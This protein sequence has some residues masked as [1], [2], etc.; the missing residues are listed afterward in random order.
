MTEAIFGDCTVTLADGIV[1]KYRVVIGDTPVKMQYW[2]FGFIPD[3]FHWVVN[4]CVGVSDDLQFRIDLPPEDCWIKVGPLGIYMDVAEI[5]C[6]F[7]FTLPDGR[8]GSGIMK[9][10]ATKSW[11]QGKGRW[12]VDA[13]EFGPLEVD[14]S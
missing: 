14:V 10:T 9:G 7:T 13:V 5:P 2:F 6:P 4:A 8:K 12:L 11:P 1:Y 3:P